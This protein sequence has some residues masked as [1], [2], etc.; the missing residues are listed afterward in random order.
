MACFII[1]VI[2]E[3]MQNTTNHSVARSEATKL[4]DIEDG[5]L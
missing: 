1:E 2:L 4:R 5:F 3:L